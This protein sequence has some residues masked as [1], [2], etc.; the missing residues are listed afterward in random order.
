MN[1][2]VLGLIFVVFLSSFYLECKA[3]QYQDSRHRFLGSFLETDSTLEFV[4][5]D[6]H[7]SKRN[8]EGKLT[9]QSKDCEEPGNN[10]NCSEIEVNHRYYVSQ[11][12]SGGKE[13]WVD[14]RGNPNHTDESD[15]S[16]SYLLRKPYPLKFKFPYYGHLLDSVVL[17]TGESKLTVEWYQVYLH[18]DTSAG[19]F[20]F[21]CTLHKNG[22]IWFAYQKIPVN[23]ANIPAL[24][25]H[26]VKV[27][28]ADAFVIEVKRR[29]VR[30]RYF[31]IYST[32]NITMESVK[33]NVAVIFKPQLN[34][35][36]AHSCSL[37][38]N[39]TEQSNFTCEWCPELNRCS[40]G[41]DRHRADWETRKCKQNAIKEL[42][43]ECK[44]STIRHDADLKASKSKQNGTKEKVHRT[45]EAHLDPQRQQHRT[46]YFLAH[47]LIT[48][49]VQQLK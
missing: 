33:D 32:I 27:G 23:V 15:L 48:L 49:A 35:V 25:Y 3:L 44:A 9:N 39:R 30:Y 12:I 8:L 14:V 37:C 46:L 11:I 6:H 5:H 1:R 18:S 34:C 2:A 29:Q 10:V 13:Y 24:P 47:S 31:Y 41:V 38:M 22:T 45:Q 40:D 20:T 21:Q 28:I 17:T 43:K 19:P 7:R 36:S 16:N 4:R 42:T 26:P